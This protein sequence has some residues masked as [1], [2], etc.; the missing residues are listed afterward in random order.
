MLL[1]LLR[2][3]I[4][5]KESILLICT[6]SIADKIVFIAIIFFLLKFI[7]FIVNLWGLHFRGDNSVKIIKNFN[8]YD[9]LMGSVGFQLYIKT[10]LNFNSSKTDFRLETIEKINWCSSWIKS[11][12]KWFSGTVGCGCILLSLS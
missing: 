12:C 7:A 5:I 2:K 10:V 8:R 6:S 1:H 3:E 9:T 4:K 11:Y